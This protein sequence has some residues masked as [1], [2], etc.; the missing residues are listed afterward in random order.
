MQ[1]IRGHKK[2]FLISFR[3]RR[4]LFLSYTFGIKTINLFIHSRSSLENHTRYQTKMG[5]V[6][7]HFQTKR[8]KN[9]TLWGGTYPWLIWRSTPGE[10]DLFNCISLLIGDRSIVKCNFILQLL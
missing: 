9:P 4:F 8:R 5:K 10:P 6:Y 7:T 3:I 2:D 1:R